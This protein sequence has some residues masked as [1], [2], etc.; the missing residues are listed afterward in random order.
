MGIPQ[1]LQPRGARILKHVIS[2]FRLHEP[3][4]EE[5]L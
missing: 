5:G 2:A 1:R 4:V 3:P